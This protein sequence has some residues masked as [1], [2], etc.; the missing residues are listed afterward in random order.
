MK[1]SKSIVTEIVINAPAARVWEILT[2]TEK[3]ADWNPFL[4]KIKGEIKTGNRLENTMKNGNSTMTFRPVV[5]QVIP[6]IYFEWLG[7][8][9]VSGIFD[10]RHYFR[11]ETLEA[12]QTKLTHG[13]EFSGLL[14]GYVLKNNGNDIRQNFVAMN[15]AIKQR[16]ENQ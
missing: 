6:E 7:K 11:L 12:N 9:W 4:L 3:Y 8:L 14:S 13:E 2:N 16:A 10:G 1:N 15:Q 5:L